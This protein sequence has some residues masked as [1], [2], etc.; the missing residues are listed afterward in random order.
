MMPAMTPAHILALVLPELDI[1][2]VI[3]YSPAIAFTRMTYTH[4]K[5]AL[6]GHFLTPFLNEKSV[7]TLRVITRRRQHVGQLSKVRLSRGKVGIRE[8]GNGGKLKEDDWT[9]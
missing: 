9:V 1:Q 4:R 2:W 5:Y 3:Q 8:D 7:Q 6:R